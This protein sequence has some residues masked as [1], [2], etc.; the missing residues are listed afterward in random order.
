MKKNI[1]NN[2]Q[3]YINVILAPSFVDVKSLTKISFVLSAIVVFTKTIVIKVNNDSS[4]ENLFLFA[5]RKIG[6]K[7]IEE[8]C[9]KKEIIK[10]NKPF[11]LKLFIYKPYAKI[12]NAVENN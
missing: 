5:R 8:L 12:A 11:L 2:E 7:K 10:Y 1:N 3:I 4:F 6:K 9:I